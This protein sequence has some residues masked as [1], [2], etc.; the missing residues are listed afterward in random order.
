MVWLGIGQKVV[1]NCYIILCVITAMV[2]LCILTPF[3][4]KITQDK[5][6]SDGTRAGFSWQ[7]CPMQLLTLPWWDVEEN[8]ES[9]REKTHMIK[10][11]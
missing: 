9:R 1:S 4:V 8:Q 6:I 11:V 7:L 10:T 2:A 5:H 3:T